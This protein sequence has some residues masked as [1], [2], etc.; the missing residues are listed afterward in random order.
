MEEENLDIS[1]D[2]SQA[3]ADK[4]D[5]Q[6]SDRESNKESDGD[7]NQAIADKTNVERD[8]ESDRESNGESD[9]DINQ[10]IA[11]K[12]DNSEDDEDQED[13]ESD[14]DSLGHE[15]PDLDDD[16]DDDE[17]D[18][19][20]DEEDEIRNQ[21]K[22]HDMWQDLAQF[23][24]DHNVPHNTTD[25]LLKVLNKHNIPGRVSINH[26]W[27]GGSQAWKQYLSFHILIFRIWICW[28]RNIFA[29]YMPK[30]KADPLNRILNTGYMKR[31]NNILNLLK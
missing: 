19:D 24:I 8:Q 17:E 25:A 16:E 28:I 27:G 7:I 12:S 26:L 13:Q 2:N 6:E 31:Q 20:N 22:V 29:L 30:K 14:R 11:N 10:E 3:I 15:Y 21:D 9:R 18:D 1:V 5:D 23:A 4:T